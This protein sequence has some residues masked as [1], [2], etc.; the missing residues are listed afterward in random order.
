MLA[1]DVPTTVLDTRLDDR[2]MV[3]GAPASTTTS[4]VI[5]AI[6]CV[7]PD[8]TE[9]VSRP[10][11]PPCVETTPRFVKVARPFV[12]VVAV[13]VPAREN[14]A[15]LLGMLLVDPGAAATAAVM[16]TPPLRTA[17]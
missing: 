11:R 1:S 12:S 10:V 2:S 5:A 16:T 15:T 4:V 3:V 9:N 6:V 13:N 14:V 17:L 8:V 7:V